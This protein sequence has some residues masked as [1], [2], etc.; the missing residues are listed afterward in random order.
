MT[1]EGK[2]L[3]DTVSLRFAFEPH[4]VKT[5]GAGLPFC[6]CCRLPLRHLERY[7]HLSHLEQSCHLFHLYQGCHLSHL[8][9]CCHLSH[10][11]W[12]H[13]HY[14]PR[15]GLLIILAIIATFILI[16]IKQ[17]LCFPCHPCPIAP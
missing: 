10:F 7:W 2:K 14:Q 1:R 17:H 3:G 8:E 12:H 9:Q 11:H 16:I 5:G 15:M 4:A 6:D 13:H